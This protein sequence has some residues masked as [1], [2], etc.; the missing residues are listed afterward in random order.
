[1]PAPATIR[2]F[3]AVS[4]SIVDGPGIRFSVFVQGCSHHC[5]GCHNPQSWPFDAG[6]DVRIDQLVERILQN[7]LALGVT[8]SGGDPF[9]QPAACAELAR[10]VKA[11]GRNIWVYTG[12]LYEDL[13]EMVAD[14]P[15]EG[16]G[17]VVGDAAQ[18]DASSE[19]DAAAV[20][21]ASETDGEEVVASCAKD[22]K[23]AR[24][25][26][27][28]NLLDLADVLVDGPF[29]QDKRSL[30]LRYRGSSNQRLIDMEKTHRAGHVVLWQTYDEYPVKPPSW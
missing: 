3:G 12:Y 28:R 30:G 4:D 14:L 17:A 5:P 29:I 10:R 7:K 13:L 1:M 26:A 9:D 24:L 15:S 19:T 21:A 18:A 2:L 22:R 11:A 16:D 6:E 8:L 23:Q 27:I 25:K 20:D